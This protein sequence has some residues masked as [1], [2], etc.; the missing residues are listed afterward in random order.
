MCG[1]DWQCNIQIIHNPVSRDVLFFAY[2]Y[3]PKFQ[4]KIELVSGFE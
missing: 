2:L 3:M 4:L 1:P